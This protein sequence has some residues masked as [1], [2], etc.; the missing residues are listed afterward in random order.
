M[1]GARLKCKC[2]CKSQA[3]LLTVMKHPQAAEQLGDKVKIL[4]VD[5][6]AN[7]QLSSM[8][9]VRGVMHMCC[10]GV[11]VLGWG[12]G[13]CTCGQSNAYDE[14]CCCCPHCYCTAM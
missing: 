3:T 8:L 7:P 6:D 11:R 2:K 12:G 9:K 1:V 5:T 4:K 13:G 14:C 10:W